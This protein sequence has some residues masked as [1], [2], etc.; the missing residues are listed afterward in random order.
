MPSERMQRQIDRLLDEAETAAAEK[1]WAY[2]A[3]C[4][5]KVLTVDAGNED[6]FGFLS[7]AEDKDSARPH[8]TT[9][10][11]PSAPEPG[12]A[13]TTGRDQRR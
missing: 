1:N 11:T 10:E 3:E 13:A 12:D 2:V 6:A 7:M 5:R 8:K 9:P 4:A